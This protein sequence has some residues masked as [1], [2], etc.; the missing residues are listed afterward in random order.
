MDHHPI[1]LHGYSFKVTQTDGGP[2]PESAQW[3]ETTVLVG[4]GQTR[5]IEFVA[6]NPGDWIMH[7]HMTHHV[8]NQMG[9]GFPNMIGVDP[10][11][12]DKKIRQLIPGYMTMGTAGMADMAH[13]RMDVPENSIPMLGMTGQ[14][15]ATILGGM[16][17]VLKVR[18]SAPTYD[19][20]GPYSFPEGTVARS[21]DP[22]Q[23]R[24]DGIEIPAVGEPPGTMDHGSMPHHS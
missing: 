13:M 10:G 12:L 23:L 4:V 19:D 11:D 16:M 9:H 1:H 21:A 15:G 6:D 5:T 17:T 14:F 2:I 8:M 22:D 7:C 24:R 3:P 18:E 20:P